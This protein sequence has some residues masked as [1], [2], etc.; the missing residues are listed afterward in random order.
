MHEIAL[1][2]AL[3]ELLE[4]QAREHGVTRVNSFRLSCG[5]L[6]GVEEHCLRT[7]FEQLCLDHPGITPSFT[8]DWRPVITF[9]C[10]CGLECEDTT[11]RG[12]CPACGGSGVLLTG[13]T[14]ELRL[15][16]LDAD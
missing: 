11:Y 14:E 2:A 9:C 15:D 3:L 5:R 10:D 7:A 6:A 8:I 16:E 4:A 1:A 13:G 12:T